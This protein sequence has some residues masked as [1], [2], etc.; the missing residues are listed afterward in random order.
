L[1]FKT[2]PD[3]GGFRSSDIS[4]KA[5]LDGSKNLAMAQFLIPSLM[6]ERG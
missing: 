5:D 1:I 3:A 2:T 6:M 4:A